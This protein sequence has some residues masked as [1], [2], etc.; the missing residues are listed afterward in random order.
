[1]ESHLFMYYPKRDLELILD[2]LHSCVGLYIQLLDDEGNQ[3]LSYGDPAPYCSLA[4]SCL[5]EGSSCIVEHRDAAKRAIEFGEPYVFCCSSGLY[6]ISYPIVNRERLFGSV[7]IGPFLM[8]GTDE[9]L[10]KY[11]A[12]TTEIPTDT[13][14]ELYKSSQS[15]KELSPEEV[16]K[17]SRLLYYLVNSLIS[18]SRVYSS[19]CCLRNSCISNARSR[20]S[21]VSVSVWLCSLISD[22]RRSVSSSSEN[23]LS[24]SR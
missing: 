20:R 6:H 22:A 5:P 15:I 16:V 14:L 2:A 3:L 10:I 12:S 8:D 18:G 7:L 13:V 11:L 4:E 1:M 9:D 21:R 24:S 17:V 19:G 23:L